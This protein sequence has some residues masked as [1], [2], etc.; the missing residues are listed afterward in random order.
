MLVEM[1]R[2][3]RKNDNFMEVWGLPIADA[4]AGAAAQS[5]IVITGTAAVAGTLHIY[6]AGKHVAVPVARNANAD[7]IAAEAMA[8]INGI[9]DLA[10]SA[11]TGTGGVVTLTC[12]WKG[13]TGNSIDVRINYRGAAGGE[14]TPIGI[15][16]AITPMTGGALNPNI[17]AGLANL[18][19]EVFDAV[20]MPY[21][22]TDNLNAMR[23]FM[24]D[25]A[26]RWSWSQMLYGHAFSAFSGSVAEAQ[27]LGSGRNDQHC[28]IIA[29]YGSP[30]PVWEI[31]AMFGAQVLKSAAVDPARPVQTLPLVGMLPP[32]VPDRYNLSERNTLLFNGIATFTVQGGVCYIERAVTTYQKNAYGVADNS[33]L[34]VE[35]MYTSSYIIRAMR[36]RITSKYGRHKL[37]DDGARFGAGQAIITPNVIRAELISLYSELETQGIVE[38][39]DLF[40]EHLI[41]ERNTQDV[42]RIDVLFPPDYVNQLRVFAVLNQFRLN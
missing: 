37:C 2:A 15:T 41:V 42:N 30:S 10:V 9:P 29:N 38:N 18:G 22:D 36:Q 19:D 8:T 31:A 3:Y 16:A 12:K 34:D 32:D 7:A 28:S 14:K 35:T 13:L 6:V 1:F 27:T 40:A 25:A 39:T 33:Y 17:S 4:S 26:G 21:T 20:I 24:D 23:D 5:T 11:A